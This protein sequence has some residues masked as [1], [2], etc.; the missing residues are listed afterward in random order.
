M[1]LWDLTWLTSPLIPN[2]LDKF[3]KKESAM[4]TL[5][6]NAFITKALLDDKFQE[7]ILNGQ[8]QERIEE[9][10]L[11]TDE[12]KTLLGIQADNLDHFIYQIER[13]IYSDE[14]T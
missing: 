13:W 12:K 4:S 10:N 7:D 14:I 2:E 8:R 11:S 6:L 5:A 1:A 9:F 3:P